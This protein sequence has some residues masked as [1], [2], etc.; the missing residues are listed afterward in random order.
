[1]ARVLDVGSTF[2]AYNQAENGDNAD[3]NALRSDWMQ[4]GDDMRTAMGIYENGQ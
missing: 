2:S 1:M 3:Y 4:T